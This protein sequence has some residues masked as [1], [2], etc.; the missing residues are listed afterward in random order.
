MGKVE[1]FAIIIVVAILSFRIYQKYIKK[2]KGDKASDSK[3][4][5][6]FISGSSTK[7]YD[8]EPYAKK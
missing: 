1:I 5:N 8:Y 4:P 6:V 3:N 2:E 7:D